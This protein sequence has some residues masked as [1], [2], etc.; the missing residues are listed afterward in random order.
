LPVVFGESPLSLL[1]CTLLAFKDSHRLSGA[2]F[3]L[4]EQSQRSATLRLGYYRCSL[5]EHA[6]FCQG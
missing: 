2:L 3:F 5:R 4:A 1:I 6:I